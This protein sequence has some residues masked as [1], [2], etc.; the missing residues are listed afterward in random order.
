M[1]RHYEAHLIGFDLAF[2]VIVAG[3]AIFFFEVFWG[4]ADFVDFLK[5]SRE[6]L[7]ISVISLAGALLGFT[8]TTVSIILAFSESSGLRLIRDSGHYHTILAIFFNAIRALG[9]TTIWALVALLADTD[10][11]PKFWATYV[12]LWSVILSGQRLYRCA[13]ILE[14][15]IGFAL[16]K[17]ESS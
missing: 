12:A 17:Q 6:G 5:G 15:V 14:R 7:Y 9:F 4:R 8:I 11:E 3:I 1:W 10:M 2:S 13:W 16:T